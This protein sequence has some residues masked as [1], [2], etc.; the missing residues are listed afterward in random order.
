MQMQLDSLVEKQVT[1][2]VIAPA[3]FEGVI[4]LGAG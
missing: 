1:P 3:G 4:D 2:P